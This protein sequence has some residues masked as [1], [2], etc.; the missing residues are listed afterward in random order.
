MNSSPT[1]FI[2]EPDRLEVA[3]VRHDNAVMTKI[4]E[5]AVGRVIA[6]RLKEMGKPRQWL[7]E[8]TGVSNGAVTHWVKTGQIGRDSA[9]SVA[10]ALGVSVDELYGQ[11]A[12]AAKP[13]EEMSLEWISTRERQLLT[14]YRQCND[15]GRQMIDLTANGA[16]K[17]DA[18]VAMKR[19]AA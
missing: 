15:M 18:I 4:A 8:K 9:L 2:F 19:N 1:Q 16:P 17:D 6:A 5:S 13:S 11:E 7:A 10:M 12:P 14:N 3:I